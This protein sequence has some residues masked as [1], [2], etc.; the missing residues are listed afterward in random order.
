MQDQP[1]RGD[2]DT[3][4]DQG[5]RRD[6]IGIPHARAPFGHGT[7]P[8]R[9]HDV[10]RRGARAG[11]RPTRAPL[12]TVQAAIDELANEE[13]NTGVQKHEPA[14]ARKQPAR[15]GATQAKPRARPAPA[16]A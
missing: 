8:I 13:A 11:A 2:A 1:A 3:P 5:A 10:G 4:M 12:A 14:P 7:S 16:G 9:P 6:R 15:T